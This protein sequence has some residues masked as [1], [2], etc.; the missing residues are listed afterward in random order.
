MNSIKSNR[1]VICAWLSLLVWTLFSDVPLCAMEERQP[2]RFKGTLKEYDARFYNERMKAVNDFIVNFNTKNSNQSLTLAD[3]TEIETIHDA[4][5]N[6]REI[7]SAR[8][9]LSGVGE[10]AN[11][12]S[13]IKVI[14]PIPFTDSHKGEIAQF[15]DNGNSI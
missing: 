10:L 4:D 13:P 1:H 2:T 3:A 15:D 8:V 14:M 5:S 7:L 11:T 12:F 6:S 9:V